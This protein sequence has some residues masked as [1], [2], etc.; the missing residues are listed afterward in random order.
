[1]QIGMLDHLQKWIFHFMKTQKHRDKYN[2]I[3][4]SMA[5]YHNLTPKNTSYEEV[6]Q[7]NRKEMNEM[8]RYLLGVVTQS[9]QGGSPAQRPSFNRAIECTRALLEFYMYA[10]CKSR[11]DATLSYMED[12]LDRFHT[13]KDVVLLRQA[14]KQAKAKTNA[15]RME[16]TK[17]WKV[18]EETNAES[19]TPSK[20]RREMITWRD[21]ISQKIDVSKVL[22]ADFNFPKI[23]L[24]SHWVEQIRRYAALHRYSAERH[25]QAH[26]TNLKDGWNASNHNL[27]YLL[28][29]ITF[30]RRIPCFEFRELKLQA[31]AQRRENSA[32]AW[33][34]L[35]SGTDQAAPLGS[36]SYAKPEFK[37]PQN[38]H[39]GKHPHAMIKDFRA[40][41]D[42]T[43]D[44]SHRVAI[45]SGTREFIKHKSRNKTYISDE[46]LHAM[47][48]CIHHGI[49]VQVE[50]LD[51][52][53]I[54]QMCRCTASQSWRGRDRRND[55]AWVKQRPGRCY[56]ALNGRLQWQLQRLFNIKLL[57]EDGTFDEYWFALVLTTLPENWGNLDPV[58]KFVQV[59]KAPAGVALQ[60]FGVGNIVSCVHVIPDIVTSSKT[61]D[62]RNEWWIVNSH[63]DLATWND[64]N[65]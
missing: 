3:W 32:A 47:E 59:R 56:G 35:H 57:D 7:W 20:K 12:A 40:L 6:S 55:W 36:Q 25:E 33:K 24:M 37:G 41:L 11:D 16:L 29:V 30:Q 15:L 46:Q 4:L 22:D 52:E 49:Q 8:S 1:M 50:G 31:L 19:W 17:K 34:V 61:G 14:G 58:S 64:V 43:Q 48:L 27:N 54:S 10:R 26:K 28:Q 2:G 44:A 60:V 45:F 38:R 42:N 18:D 21:Y 65:N 5:A 53:H 39:D 63:I 9:L 62:E 13:I 23:H 51:G